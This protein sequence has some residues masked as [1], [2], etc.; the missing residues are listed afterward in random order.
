MTGGTASIGFIGF[1]FNVLGGIVAPGASPGEMVVVGEYKLQ[2]TATHQIEIEGTTP[3]TQFDR[4]SA[5]TMVIVGNGVTLEVIVSDNGYVPAEGD[6]FQVLKLETYPVVGEFG[7]YDLS[8]ATLTGDLVWS[9]RNLY[10]NGTL[11][12]TN[13]WDGDTVP[14]VNEL[15]PRDATKVADLPVALQRVSS[16]VTLWMDASQG[17]SV[18]GNLN[19]DVQII[20]DLSGN[21]SHFVPHATGYEPQLIG[22]VNG[23]TYLQFTSGGLD[24]VKS[25]QTRTLAFVSSMDLLNTTT[26]GADGYRKYFLY[27]TL[28]PS[29]SFAG[30]SKSSQAGNWWTE[31][32]HYKGI[33]STEGTSI[34]KDFIGTGGNQIN[35]L[36]A[37]ET[38]DIN[39][40]LFHDS[41]GGNILENA[42]LYEFI[43]FDHDLSDIDRIAIE[44]YLNKKW[45]LTTTVTTSFWDGVGN[46]DDVSQGSNWAPSGVPNSSRI[47]VINQTADTVVW[48][49]SATTTIAELRLRDAFTGT[50]TLPTELTIN[51]SV[52]IDTGS[53]TL[54][55]GK[56]LKAPSLSITG[57]GA[58]IWTGGT[59][60]VDEISQSITNSAGTLSPGQS[61]GITHVSGNYTQQAGGTLLIELGGTDASIPQFDQLFVSGNITL[62][63]TLVITTIN[64]FVPTVGDEF[65]ILVSENG[66]SGI[67]GTFDAYDFSAITSTTFA[68][69]TANLYVTGIITIKDLLDADGDGVPIPKD[70]YPDDATLVV[71]IPTAIDIT[72]LKLWL[73]GSTPDAVATSNA[74]DITKWYDFSGN[75]NHGVS[76]GSAKPQ[77][78][79][80]GLNSLPVVDFDSGGGSNLVLNATI[81]S[82]QSLFFVM[83]SNPTNPAF[84]NFV[85]VSSGSDNIVGG[86]GPEPGYLVLPLGGNI[87]F[88]HSS[89]DQDFLYS[90]GALVQDQS[91]FFRPSDFA[92]ITLTTT[93]NINVTNFSAETGGTGR[94][95]R[96]EYAEIIIYNR[97][98]SE[99]ERLE[100]NYY[101]SAK[102]GLDSVNDSDQDGIVDSI[103]FFPTDNTKVGGTIPET[104]PYSQTSTLNIALGSTTD[105]TKLVVTGAYTP[106]SA[107][108]V[109]TKT[110]FVP[111]LN[112]TFDIL[113]FTPFTGTIPTFSA[114]ILPTLSAEHTW[115]LTQ[116]YVDGTIK[117]IQGQLTPPNA[118]ADLTLWLDATDPSNTGVRP[119]DSTSIGT[120][121]DKSRNG[122]DFVQATEADKPLFIE[123]G[124]RA[125][126]VLRFDGSTDELRG[127]VPLVA[128][129][130]VFVVT[131]GFASSSYIFSSDNQNNPIFGPDIV[132]GYG[133]T[134][135]GYFASVSGG[136]QPFTTT[137]LLLNVAILTHKDDIETVGYFNNT[138][139]FNLTSNL[140]PYA[141]TINWTTVG[142]YNDPGLYFT[143]DIAE[144]IIYNQSLSAADRTTVYNYLNEKW[145]GAGFV[146]SDLPYGIQLDS[147][148]DGIVDH[149]DK[150]QY[151]AGFTYEIT[152]DRPTNWVDA[153]AGNTVTIYE[154]EV[155]LNAA[156]EIT[157]LVFDTNAGKTA[158]LNINAGLF[159]ATSI[160][161]TGFGTPTLN[162]VGGI[163]SVPDIDVN[164]HN[165][166]GIVSPG[167]SAEIMQISG[168][169]TQETGA[170]L[171]IEIGGTTAAT[172]DF[173][174]LLV[175][176][177]IVLAGTLKV[178]TLN[179]TLQFG[180]TFRILV[181]DSPSTLTGTFDSFDLQTPPA[182]L[183][184]STASLYTT[185]EISL[186]GADADNDGVIGVP[187]GADIY[188]DDPTRVLDFPSALE[189]ISAN[190]SMW[191]VA[192]ANGL[193]LSGSTVTK[194]FDWSGSQNHLD[195]VGGTPTY[196]TNQL[197]GQ[198]VISIDG[199][200][201]GVGDGFR[202]SADDVSSR[203]FISVAKLSST[204]G[205]FYL[206]DQLSHVVP[207]LR[208]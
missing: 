136:A 155:N 90:N 40:H 168:N 116:F 202:T 113:D 38:K 27:N 206:E 137:D 14:D 6:S 13:D 141:P 93:L 152:D 153:E 46:T 111:A 195:D 207:F 148:N 194:W 178:T 172:P 60:S 162:L 173:D 185:G 96:G 8:Q 104:G 175:S 200:S 100:I 134:R 182:G 204:V 11:L 154:G 54:A 119:A 57:S 12:V 51:G 103:D 180:D 87:S 26:I 127:S 120:W 192:T 89:H 106:G 125:K 28:S 21:G 184:W 22:F 85:S 20:Y 18:S 44:A 189:T 123:S 76:D 91:T 63:G 64:N 35:V 15:Y 36:K 3:V 122:Y 129:T 131:T 139:V 124:A 191:M 156:E 197:G 117:V 151:T 17:F 16:N 144:I 171:S 56:T 161:N 10:T 165:L 150:F 70:A 58:L 5:N 80:D 109:L 108:N 19:E 55:T 130:S 157:T 41:G 193:E 169:Y 71:D 174:Q 198:P 133:G 24:T 1:D 159:R 147:D 183:A 140:Q 201:S 115:D 121:V 179:Y 128:E 199:A 34:W 112:N 92:L 53:L 146:S 164:V 30:Y 77:I 97:V 29:G 33:L 102:W 138:E 50:V 39:T 181:W 190:I 110:G 176:G 126:N 61:A 4:V 94:S 67:I 65:K 160:T 52:T 69:S 196:L 48:D 47:V 118:F 101:L 208:C 105:F 187:Y 135:V 72:G 158:A 43:S 66:P 188:D 42:K 132:T 145:I 83:R 25:H 82:A 170:T 78:L 74:T 2:G 32:L 166:G 163:F 59:L 49:G 114:Y 149:Y 75:A 37:T 7:V 88:G 98:I 167:L 81:Q 95:W 205:F 99:A 203:T 143:G 177:N 142:S 31:S 79:D 86:N 9:T 186:I 73:D 107:L 84:T 23:K 45:N 68:V 62:A